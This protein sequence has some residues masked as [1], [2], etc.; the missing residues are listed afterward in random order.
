MVKVVHLTV[1]EILL[2]RELLMK[3]LMRSR[4]ENLRKVLDNK[5]VLLQLQWVAQEDLIEE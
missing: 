2:T 4:V 3:P 1:R 5:E